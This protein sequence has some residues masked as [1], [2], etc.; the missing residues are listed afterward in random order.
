MV[1]FGVASFISLT[2]ATFWTGMSLLFHLPMLCSGCVAVFSFILSF[3]G[4]SALMNSEN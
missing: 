2:I 4:L 3:V 1:K